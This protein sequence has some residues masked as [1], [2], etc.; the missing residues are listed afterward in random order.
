MYIAVVSPAGPPPTTRQSII[1]IPS[2]SDTASC[3]TATPAAVTGSPRSHLQGPTSCGVRL[4]RNRGPGQ[5]VVYLPR[6]F[7]RAGRNGAFNSA[8]AKGVRLIWETNVRIL[9]VG[10]T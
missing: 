6:Q 2:P 3:R 4:L 5:R 1:S 9:I 7:H 10:A 8:E